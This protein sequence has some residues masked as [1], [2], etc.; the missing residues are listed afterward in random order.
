MKV[1]IVGGSFDPIHHGHLIMAE[2]LKIE[3][4]LDKIIFIPTGKAPHKT[5]INSGDV[6]LKMVNLA[7]EG[8]EHFLSCSIEINNPNVTY[9]I[10]TMKELNLKYPD[11]K[12]Y[13]II[14][15]DNLFNMET[16]NSIDELGNYT[17]FLVSHRIFEEN[18]TDSKVLEKCKELEAKY[19]LDI[20][21]VDTPIIEISSSYI[22]KRVN[23]NLSIDYLTTERVIEYIESNGLYK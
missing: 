13:F 23:N 17:K 3:K 22:R 12:F 19:K 6:R 8:K 20:E 18:I 5:Y 7:I 2:H 15:L 10:D 11:C 9:T 16:W 21:I 14:G 4:N 1:G